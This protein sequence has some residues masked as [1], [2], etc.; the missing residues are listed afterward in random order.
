[1]FYPE[2]SEIMNILKKISALLLIIALAAGVMC[3]CG[4]DNQQAENT[5]STPAADAAYTVTVVDQNGNAVA[6]VVM[7]LADEE[8]TTQ[9]VVTGED[10]TVSVDSAVAMECVT[11]SS[12]PEGYTADATVVS[13]EGTDLTIVLQGEENEDTTVTYTVTIVDQNGDPVPGVTLQL[14]DDEACKL[15]VTTDENGMATATYE[16]SNY[17]V[18]L[19]ELPGGY[20]SEV[21]EFSLDGM[22]EITITINLD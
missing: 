6:N 9:L 12:I 13:F 15:P 19:T 4:G 1:M 14:C 22:T 3:G 17:H 18:T 11:L 2:R 21:M 16:A 7:Q 5:E 8:G 20:S 10:G